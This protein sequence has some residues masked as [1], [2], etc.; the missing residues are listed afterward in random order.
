MLDQK[1]HNRIQRFLLI[2]GGVLLSISAFAQDDDD[3]DASEEIEEVIVTGSRIVRTDLEGTSPVQI[4]ERIQIARSGQTSIG[5]LLREIPSVAGGAQTTQINNGGDGTNRISLRGLGS[6]RTL[7]LMN[8]RRLPP[9]STGLASTNLSSAVDL[10]TIPVS[11]VDRIDVFKDGASAIYGSDAVAGVVNIVTRRDFQGIEMNVQ[12]GVTQ[13]GDGARN[14]IDLTIGGSSDNGSFMAYAGYV[15]EG[16]ICACDRDWADTPLAYFG[17]DVIFLGSSAPPWGRYRF[18]Q[19]EEAMDL[20]RGP[21][22]GDFRPFNFFGGDS[23]NFA[24]SNHQ[25]Q[26]SIR[27]SMMFV[28]D[29][30]LTDFPVLGDVRAFVRA[31]YLNRDSNQKLAETPLAPLAFFSFNAPYSKDNFYNPFG[32]DIPDWRRR[33]VEDGSRTEDT[34]TETKQLVIG[35][36]GVFGSWSWDAYHAFGETASEGHFGRIYNL[37]KVANAAGPSLKD[38]DGNWVLDS[39]GNPMCAND[40]E[41][42]VVLNTF[43]QN[44]VTQAMIDYITFVDNQSS[45]Q[46]QKIYAV[47]FI[48]SAIL[49]RDAGPVGMALGWEWREE[50]GADTPDSQVNALGSGATGTPRKPTSGGYTVNEFYGELN[51]PLIAYA[52]LFELLETNI[53]I[54]FSDYDS[55]GATTNGKFGLKYR[56]FDGLTLRT[57]FSQSFRAPSTSNLFGGSGFSF[58][59]L[60]D[61]CSQNPTQFCIADGVP[62]SGFQPISTQIRTTVGGNPTAQPETADTLTYGVVYKPMDGL[63]ITVDRFD[64]AL[65]DALTT[66]GANFILTQCATN[67]NFC[68]L[69]ERFTSGPNAGNPINVVNTITNVGGVDT[70]GWD[71]GLY[72]DWGATFLGDVSITYEASLLS[73]YLITRA[74]NTTDDLTGRFSDDLDGYFTEYRSSTS[75][76]VER[77]AF[78]FSYQMRIIG[79]ADEE[80]TDFATGATLERT[81]EGRIYHDIHANLELPDHNMSLSGGIDNLMNEEPPLSL[82]GFNDNTDVRTFDTAGRYFFFKINYAM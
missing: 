20:T 72:Y 27:W 58:P 30:N 12:T 66:L 33:M 55:F 19:G 59:A 52:D 18:T 29:Q 77:D 40:T 60:A 23:Y 7:V 2:L 46:D 26:P 45:L 25:R 16:N 41:N 63:A 1:Y 54:R 76:V 13:E 21:E 49:E 64:V 51:I 47:N 35:L 11:M 9:S 44:S 36:E 15:D 37:E 53:A 69:I 34:L 81:V 62:A 68:N 50:R 79:E 82:D 3:E 48:N 57:S 5:Q 61:P 10:N 39:D 75:V 42:C 74:D 24:P 4:F 8:G 78:T 32:A 80:F 17:G 22:Y 6:T 67:G 43:G 14:V 28:G 70:S 31:S 38:A 65:T 71:I 73:E 56:P